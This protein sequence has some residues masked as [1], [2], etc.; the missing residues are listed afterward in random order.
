MT[1]RL[2]IVLAGLVSVEKV[3]LAVEIARALDVRKQ[4][5]LLIDDVA[6][7]PVDANRA[8]GVTVQRVSGDL[9]PQLEMLINQTDTDAVIVAASETH[10]PDSLFTTLDALRGVNLISFAMIDTRTC[11]C[12]PHARDLLEGYADHVISLP[13]DLAAVMQI[14]DA[15][16]SG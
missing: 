4:R 7:L 12:F 9:L 15:A 11:D 1:A 14:L 16:A 10:S 13:Y 2:V 3:T 8:G 6:R 5:V